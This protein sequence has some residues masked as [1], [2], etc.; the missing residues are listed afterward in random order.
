M[1]HIVQEEDLPLSLTR[2]HPPIMIAADGERKTLR[3]VA[4]YA[5]ACGLR[6]GPQVPEKLDVLKKHCE[7]EG[8]DYEEIEDLRVLLR[9]R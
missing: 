4:H 1:A 9:R 3:L 5:N 8:R 7:A 6:P 2:P